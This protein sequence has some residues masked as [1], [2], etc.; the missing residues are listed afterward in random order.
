MSISSSLHLSF[1]VLETD[2]NICM[3]SG[4]RTLLVIISVLVS[5]A[6]LVSTG[7]ICFVCQGK[8][9]KAGGAFVL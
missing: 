2:D 1:Q 3:A 8:L 5:L 6:V 7:V 4:N 9:K